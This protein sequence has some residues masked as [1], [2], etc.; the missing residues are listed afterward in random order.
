MLNIFMVERSNDQL[1]HKKSTPP[2]TYINTNAHTHTHTHTRHTQHTYTHT[3]TTHTHNTYAHRWDIICLRRKVVTLDSE[4]V[5]S[6]YAP[7]T[8]T[9]E[10]KNN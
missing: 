10:S 4:P 9:R 2:T 5:P 1:C 8:H 7:K 3:H 6:Y